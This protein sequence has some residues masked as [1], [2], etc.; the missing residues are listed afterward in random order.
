MIWAD[1]CTCGIHSVHQREHP[2]CSSYTALLWNAGL[3]QTSDWLYIPL[4][5]GL[6]CILPARHSSE[7]SSETSMMVS[8]GVCTALKAAAPNSISSS[9]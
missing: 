7:A 1:S 6:A 4:S 9:E 2:A 8:R 3:Q 5:L